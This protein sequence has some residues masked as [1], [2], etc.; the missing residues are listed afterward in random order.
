MIRQGLE[1]LGIVKAVT[2]ELEPECSFKNCCLR[3]LGH[4]EL[5]SSYMEQTLGEPLLEIRNCFTEFVLF[6]HRHIWVQKNYL[7][8][9][10]LPVSFV[11]CRRKHRRTG[12]ILSGGGGGGLNIICPNET[13]WLQMILS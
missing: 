8:A 4:F 10:V 6:F 7:F 2:K 12:K 3:L 11:F 13:C 9:R 1:M 5:Q